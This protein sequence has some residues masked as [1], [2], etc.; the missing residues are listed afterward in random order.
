M[1]WKFAIHRVKK[2]LLG[3]NIY[4]MPLCNS[5][6]GLLLSANILAHIFKKTLRM[7]PWQN[8][9]ATVVAIERLQQMDQGS[10]ADKCS[11]KHMNDPFFRLITYLVPHNLL[12]CGVLDFFPSSSP[13][14]CGR[15][16]IAAQFFSTLEKW[17]R[18][19]TPRKYCFQYAKHR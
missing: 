17:G 8:V 9:Y 7:N 5:S 2:W 4:W 13:D 19:W 14:H 18:F 15:S 10:K 6:T 1:R 16:G 3:W 11:I 12:F